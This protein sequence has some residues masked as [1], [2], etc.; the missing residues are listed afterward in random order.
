MKLTNILLPLMLLVSQASIAAIKVTGNPHQA[1]SETPDRSTGLDEIIVVWDTSTATATYRASS[2]SSRPVWYRYGNLGGGYAEPIGNVSYNGAES[3]ISLGADDA[4]YIVEDGSNRYYFW[5]VNYSRHYME[6]ADA[7]PGPEQDCDRASIIVS[8]KADK[9]M[10][11][12]INGRGLEL[13]RDIKVNYNTLEFDGDSFSYRQVATTT[14]VADITGTLRVPSPLCD[15]RFEISGDRFL[16]AWGLEESVTSPTL[17]AKAVRCETTAVQE[18]RES[19]NEKK[20][21]GGGDGSLG[22]SAPCDIT[23]TAA[24]TDA[25]IFTEWQFST[26]SEFDDITMRVNQLEARQ[27]FREEGTTYVRFM[28]ANSAGDCE[29]YGPT[30]TINIGASILE[31]P[32]AFSPGASE[33]VNDEWKVSYKSIID[34]DCHIFNRWGTELCSFTDPSLG[35]DGKYNGKV[36]PAGVYFYVIKAKGA[37]GKEYK[38][39]GDINVINYK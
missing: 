30:Y 29:S 11:Y 12:T 28:C 19:S 23:F 1:L 39:S 6:L 36:V 34:F 20:A 14:S 15:T 2:P 4:G 33:G 37:D 38:L 5:V 32:N 16:R 10:Y 3:S 7:V 24:A 18:T 9:I 25:A 26:T 35:W 13:D 21:D 31:C 17:T 27:V 22:G 8:G